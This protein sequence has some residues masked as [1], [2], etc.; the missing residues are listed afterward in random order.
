MTMNE[1]ASPTAAIKGPDFWW[2]DLNRGDVLRGT[3]MTMTDAHL[4]QWAGLT[5]D[6]VPLHLDKEYASTTRFGE[7]IVHGP[8]TL[9]LTLG[10][11]TQTGYF[12]NVVAWL[13]LDGLRALRP[14]VVGD[15]VRPEAELIE[16]RPAKNPDQGIWTFDYTTLNQRG[17]SV[18][19]FRSSLLIRRRCEGG[20]NA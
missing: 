8:F 6:T 7:R 3:G 17:E 1:V 9:A 15:T 18:M 20:S 4:I 19:T 2:E 11:A 13:G 12:N 5:G 10:L 14:V 16:T